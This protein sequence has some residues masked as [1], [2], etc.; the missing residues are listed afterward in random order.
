MDLKEFKAICEKCNN[1]EW[2]KSVEINL[3]SN[4]CDFHK[5]FKGVVSYFK[6]LDTEIK[7][8]NKIFNDTKVPELTENQDSIESK[9]DHLIRFVNRVLETETSD[10]NYH[11]SVYMENIHDDQETLFISNSAETNFIISLWR[12]NPN[13][14]KGAVHFLTK[15]LENSNWTD[16]N[17]QLFGV[18]AAYEFLSKDSLV[19]NRKKH[20]KPVFA[21][22]RNSFE[23]EIETV[24]NKVLDTAEELDT[25][26]DNFQNDIQ[27]F[28][29]IKNEN[30]DS[31]MG[32]SELRNTEFYTNAE[33]RLKELEATYR[34]KL[35][36][37]G[38]AEYWNLRAT[39]LK[40]SASY[41]LVLTAFSAICGLILFS[42]LATTLTAEHI[43]K[44]IGNPAISIRWSILSVLSVA[45]VV[46][47]VRI[48]TKLTMSTYHLYRDAQERQQLTYVYLSL[49]KDAEIPDTDR[50][51]IL[52]SLFSR[53]DTGLL[54]E[55]SGPT[56]PNSVIEKIVPK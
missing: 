44:E 46:F 17:D 32:E 10:L 45:L 26:K 20:E 13:Y 52:Q 37:E 35:M 31:W 56:M 22:L 4:P 51:I 39:A 18:F 8:W 11:W 9:L 49:K 12:L 47:L 2:L 3:N 29:T 23:K 43:K 1:Q 42:I 36:L 40:K 15:Q 34:D 19:T 6:F 7:N 21:T 38:P 14:V 25:I 33:Q 50:H 28:H 55:D 48:F 54:K 27:S 16:D 5:K 41:W 30:F 24:S 53:S